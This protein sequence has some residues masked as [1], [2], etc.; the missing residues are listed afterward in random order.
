MDH[1][2]LLCDGGFTRE[3]ECSEGSDFFRFACPPH[4]AEPTA[5]R[6]DLDVPLMLYSWRGEGVGY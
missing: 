1:N 3:I 4:R 6:C 5:S 2:S